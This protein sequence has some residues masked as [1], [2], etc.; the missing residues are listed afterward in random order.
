MP[1]GTDKFLQGAHF[2]R[3]PL[4]K[5]AG[6]VWVCKCGAVYTCKEVKGRLAWLLT[7]DGR[8]K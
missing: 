6:K 5:R 4:I 8:W 2:C 7:K 1:G 3:T